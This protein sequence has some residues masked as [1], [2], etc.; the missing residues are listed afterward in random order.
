M[1]YLNPPYHIINGVSVFA[2]HADPLQFYYLPMMP[3]LTMLKDPKS[4]K[5][6]PQIQVIKFRGRAGGGGFLNFD[7]NIGV[8]Q[9]VLDDVRAE[10]KRLQRLSAT[11]RLGPVPLVGGTVKM[12]LF[13]TQSG[14][15]PTDQT[16]DARFV[17]KVNHHASPAMYGDNQAAFSVRL[18]EEGVTLLD[19]ALQG[20]MSPIGVVYSLNFLALRPAYHVK[21]KIDW[22]RV[23]KHMDE[24]FSTK[25][26]FSSTEITKAVDELVDNRAI[27][28][29][30][31]TFVPEGDDSTAGITGRRD[32]AINDVREMM[33]NAYFEPSLKPMD[34][35][36]DG[37]DK[38][39]Q[40]A[41]DL[42]TMAVTGGW[43]S[44]ASF[45]Y[46]KMDYRRM[47]KKVLNV[48]MSERTTVQRT[49]APQG[50][51]AGLFRILQDEGLD[52]NRFILQADLD[53]P[54]FARRKVAVISRAAFEEDSIG[55]LNVNLRYNNEPKNVIL[56]PAT[57]RAELDWASRIEGGSMRREVT[58]DYKVT[59][60]G[61]DGAERPLSLT[62]RP[63]VVEVDNLEIDPRELY[64]IEH[65]PVIALGFPWKQYPNVEVQLR[66]S[67]PGNGINQIDNFILNERKQED[68]WRMFVRDRARLRFQ[69]KLIF[70]AA[71][72]K[73]VTMSWV[74]TDEM[75]VVVRNP[76]PRQ[77]TLMIVPNFRWAE[78][79][80]A[81]VDVSYEDKANR[82]SESQ[83]FE[84]KED[85]SDTQTFSVDLA[86]PDLRR[87]A[88]KVTIMFADGRLLEIP[89]SYT[90]MDRI[91]VRSDM[92]GHKIVQLRPAPVNF[93]T[94]KVREMIVET[95]YE[96]ADAGLSASDT[97]SFK[98]MTDNGSFEYDYV[99]EAKPGYEWRVT[100]RYTNGMSKATQWQ[101]A[102]AADLVVPVA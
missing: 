11:P 1:L 98:S 91:I 34:R 70:R 46:K 9:D 65:V 94:K 53:D 31:D 87:V 33:T 51:L 7:C 41:Q 71:N 14:E 36:K 42:S 35:G 43:A 97:Y 100:Y 12:M 24:T 38:A 58:F 54:W 93:Q 5:R 26:F 45:G 21:L 60:K 95:R 86:N 68:V 99:D 80:R 82:I 76:F 6:I 74:E 75:Q 72:H 37:W 92:K 83:S 29:Q 102:T 28:L 15:P 81:F 50:H 66:Y 48:N 16:P 23:Q 19:K 64:A 18:D 57:P 4:G 61:I 17:L 101:K 10:L 59:F 62:S 67:D 40:L 73:D 89:Q 13:G 79:E 32:Q 8:E 44:V 69:Y 63:Q 55:S 85:A 47:D 96:D 22:D 30:V 52:V 84:F 77:R 78:V 39:T 56:D 88:Y 3:K 90:R 27:D 20:E 2:D 49:I 25:V